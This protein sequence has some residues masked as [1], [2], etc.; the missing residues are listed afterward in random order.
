MIDQDG[1]FR[2]IS[3][4]ARAAINDEDERARL[5]IDTDYLK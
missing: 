3:T 5:G 4:D 1:D 2:V